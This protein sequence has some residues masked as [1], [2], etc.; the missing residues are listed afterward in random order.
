MLK[1]ADVPEILIS[2]PSHFDN[3]LNLMMSTVSEHITS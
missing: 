2:I 3:A 1:S